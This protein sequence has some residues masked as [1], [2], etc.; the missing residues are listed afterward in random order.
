MQKNVT[1]NQE[2]NQSLERDEEITDMRE[3]TVS[4]FKIIIKNMV[5][6]SKKCIMKRSRENIL[7]RNKQNFWS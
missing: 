6:D 2:K 4:Y 1:H 7:T 5:K 3:L